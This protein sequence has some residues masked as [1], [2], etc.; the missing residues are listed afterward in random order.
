[1]VGTSAEE[2]TTLGGAGTPLDT[3]NIQS[4][5][6]LD[7]LPATQRPGTTTLLADEP[8]STARARYSPGV[9]PVLEALERVVVEHAKSK[10]GSLDTD[11]RF[12]KLIELLQ[13]L[14]RAQPTARLNC[15]ARPQER[16]DEL[17]SR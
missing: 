1:M 10:T 7:L 4:A 11:L 5:S 15:D 9:L 13:A 16:R 12:W 3:L 17:D 14:K 2:D 6:N 8:E